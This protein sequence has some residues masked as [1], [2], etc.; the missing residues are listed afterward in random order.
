M[1][2]VCTYCV[3]MCVYV[4]IVF[5]FVASSLDLLEETMQ[6]SIIYLNKKNKMQLSAS[7]FVVENQIDPAYVENLTA[8]INNFFQI[9][10]INYIFLKAI[11]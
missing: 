4:F 10:K 9:M 5:N 7:Y 3:I 6:A 2:I 11:K 8:L 1:Y